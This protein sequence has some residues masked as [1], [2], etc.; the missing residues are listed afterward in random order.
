[1]KTNNLLNTYI[2]DNYIIDVTPIKKNEK[3][4]F[5]KGWNQKNNTQQERE[6]C[7]KYTPHHNNIGVMAGQTIRGYHLAIIDFDNTVKNK[8]IIQTAKKT[9]EIFY[10]KYKDQIKNKSMIIR[11]ANGGYHLYFLTNIKIHKTQYTHPEIPNSKLDICSEPNNRQ[12]L[13]WGSEINKK[14]YEIIE[15]NL[16]TLFNI[17]FEKIGLNFKKKFTQ[18]QQPIKTKTKTKQNKQKIK[19]SPEL[20]KS[21]GETERVAFIRN[22]F[23][24][25]IKTCHDPEGNDL[26]NYLIAHDNGSN[27]AEKGIEAY[28]KD[29]KAW[30]KKIN[31]IQKEEKEKQQQKIKKKIII[32]MEEDI[33]KQKYQFRYNIVKDKIEIKNPNNNKI[34]KW[35][36]DDENI[37]A[38]ILFN[39]EK[40]TEYNCQKNHLDTIIRNNAYQNSYD[41]GLDFCQNLSKIEKEQTLNEIFSL[42]Y[43]EDTIDLH[44]DIDEPN[45]FS[46]SFL[47]QLSK[48]IN[49]KDEK[50]IRSNFI[51]IVTWFVS[52]IP[53]MQGII[54]NGAKQNQT[55]LIFIGGEGLGKTTLC[56]K[57]TEELQ[58]Y[59][60]PHNP[61][62]DRDGIMALSTNLFVQLDD[63]DSEEELGTFKS[64]VTLATT[65][66]RKA[67]GRET[68]TRICRANFLATS[69]EHEII[70]D[71]KSTRRYFIIE[72]EN[73]I[74]DQIQGDFIK[75]CWCEANWIYNSNK[76]NFYL[77]KNKITKLK[78]HNKK[79]QKK[80]IT[81][82]ILEEDYNVLPNDDNLI[83]KHGLSIKDIF[84]Q[85]NNKN[86]TVTR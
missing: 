64:M 33:Q 83:K 32:K 63:I 40:N 29:C 48:I 3:I 72:I 86:R 68:K 22:N 43:G 55:I 36:T 15:G 58:G 5:I 31:E 49:D 45:P 84:L 61:L 12:F 19:F 53:T 23:P 51:K 37:R 73:E 70:Y 60:F 77:N 9:Y 65:N 69:N 14:Q 76:F 78:E 35:T 34:K 27:L 54:K 66:A 81:Y 11:T 26:Y 2:I 67:Y 44:Y 74:Q 71:D 85:I 56:N 18:D 30:M 1:M 47:Y 6:D 24:D 62:K 39:L 21:F 50:I 57:I 52:A 82:K 80:D 13:G 4:P 75:K 8:Q 25:I 16:N 10:K 46:T 20:E 41:V 79:Y 17:Q 7:I 38:E 28:K 59:H 42:I